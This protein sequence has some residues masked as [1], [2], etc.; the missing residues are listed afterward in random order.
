MLCCE[1][2]VARQH[3]HTSA[4]TTIII[5]RLTLLQ[6]EGGG[7]GGEW[8][9]CARRPT[10]EVKRFLRMLTAAAAATIAAWSVDVKFI[11][12]IHPC[13]SVVYINKYT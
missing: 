3:L 13:G 1:S 9:E 8:R 4:T 11:Y 5:I 12:G 6:E 7:E 10:N 2:V